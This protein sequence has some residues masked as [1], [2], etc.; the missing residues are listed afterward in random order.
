MAIQSPVQA[1]DD[2][3]ARAAA[4]EIAGK[5]PTSLKVTYAL[6]KRARVADRLETCLV[7]E[8]RAACSLLDE[9]DL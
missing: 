5:S 8:Y 7:N 9:H 4:A 6:L 1:S 2:P 3:F